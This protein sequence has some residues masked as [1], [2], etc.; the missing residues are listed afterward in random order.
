MDINKSL[1]E[2]QSARNFSPSDTVAQALALKS[3]K[4]LWE[5]IT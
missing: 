3:R 1:K 5:A 4:I 2:G